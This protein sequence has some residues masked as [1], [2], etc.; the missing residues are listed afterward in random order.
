MGKHLLVAIAAAGV[1]LGGSALIRWGKAMPVGSRGART[2]LR[3]GVRPLAP[4]PP[5][6]VSEN[7][8][9]ITR[10]RGTRFDWSVAAI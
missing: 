6:P 4:R 10:N 8:R 3:A 7:F 5:P 1:L 2:R 9:G